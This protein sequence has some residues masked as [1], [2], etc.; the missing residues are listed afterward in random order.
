MRKKLFGDEATMNIDFDKIAMSGT[1][2][3]GHTAATVA[4]ENPN[5]KVALMQD[6]WAVAE[7]E[8]VLNGNVQLKIPFQLLSSEDSLT[9]IIHIE[10]DYDVEQH[11]RAYIDN[12]DKTQAYQ[13]LV[14]KGQHLLEQSD[15]W[16]THPVELVVNSS[17]VPSTQ[18]YVE[19][20][21]IVSHFQMKYM[22]RIGFTY[23]SQDDW[24][25]PDDA[26][27]IAKWVYSCES[28]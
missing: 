19:S 10:N 5:V 23:I 2:M 16:F 3:G 28:N 14:I 18:Y 15:I 26:D 21:Y 8:M 6:N 20:A 27:F 13:Y 22:Q 9:E 11:Y 1:F 12:A 7:S 17:N 25:P 4:A 24:L